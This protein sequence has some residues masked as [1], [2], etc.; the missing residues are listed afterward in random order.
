MLKYVDVQV[1]NNKPKIALKGRE[2]VSKCSSQIKTLMKK[3]GYDEGL[4]DLY[5]S[6]AEASNSIKSLPQD[7]KD[8]INVN[9]YI[10]KYDLSESNRQETINYIKNSIK[11]IEKDLLFLTNETDWQCKGEE[12]FCRNLCSFYPKYCNGGE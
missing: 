6:Q 5:L 10:R 9:V 8:L 11:N 1:G 12:F 2:W 4:I 7:I 3:Q